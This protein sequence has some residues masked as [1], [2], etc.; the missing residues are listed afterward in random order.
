[1]RGEMICGYDYC[2]GEIITEKCK[3]CEA[4]LIDA[5]TYE[6]VTKNRHCYIVGRFGG[7]CVRDNKEY[8]NLTD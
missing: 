2:N 3:G 1:M 8:P 7:S 4:D 6:D 5:S